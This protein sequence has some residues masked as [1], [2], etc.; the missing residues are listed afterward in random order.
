[1]FNNNELCKV[2][3]PV[4]PHFAIVIY[5]ARQHLCRPPHPY[6]HLGIQGWHAMGTYFGVMLACPSASM[7]APIPAH[8]EI[9]SNY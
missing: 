5:K 9:G 3:V 7:S 6:E 4:L 2:R 8:P 1:M